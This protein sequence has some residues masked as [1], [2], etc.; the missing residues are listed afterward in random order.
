MSKYLANSDR[1]ELSIAFPCKLI[2]SKNVLFGEKIKYYPFPQNRNE[3]EIY[4]YLEKII[5]TTTPDIVHIFGTEFV[6]TLSMVNVCNQR[7]IKVLISIQGLVSI[8]AQHYM[9]NLPRKI[10]N[11]FTFRDLIKKDNLVQQQKKFEQRGFS[12]VLALKKVKHVLG[13]TMWDKACALQINPD[14]QYHYCNETLREEFYNSVWNIKKIEEHSIF[15]SQGTYPIKGLHHMLEAMPIILKKFPK[16]K[17]YIG[18]ID[19]FNIRG[20]KAKLKETSYAKYLNHLIGKYKLQDKVSF[21]GSLDENEMC[22]RFLKSNVFVCPSSIENSPNSLGEAMILGVPCVAS[23]VGGI[24]DL[25]LDKQEG[26]LYQADAPYMLAHYVCEIFADND[27]ALK[28][29]NNA[30][31]R[32]L[33]THNREHNLEKLSQIYKNIVSID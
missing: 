4:K 27:L 8:Y 20:L 5:E 23:Y 16:A 24:S 29:S 13:R 2:S 12:E 11:S 19:I 7:K 26:F 9:A 17:L 1:I 15:V 14:I 32:A 28:F 6:H 22:N 10:Q 30:R 25:L 3:H 18:G 21:T 31:V 33:K